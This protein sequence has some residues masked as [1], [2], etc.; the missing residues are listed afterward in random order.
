MKKGWRIVILVACILV[1]VAI[2]VV[3]IIHYYN[4]DIA[5]IWSTWGLQEDNTTINLPDT[6]N[7]IKLLWYKSSIYIVPPI[8]I[9]IGLTFLNHKQINIKKKWYFYLIQGFSFWYLSLLII[10]LFCNEILELDRCYNI[11]FFNGI[12]SMQLLVGYIVSFIL[13]SNIELNK[14][15]SDE[16]KKLQ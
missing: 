8:F 7:Y 5:S 13:K 6:V 2:P 3:T 10:K 4:I 9:F 16:V 1:A 12:E 11:T 15:Y 14:P